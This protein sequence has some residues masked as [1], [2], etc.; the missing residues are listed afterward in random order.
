MCTEHPQPSGMTRRRLLQGAVAGL[1]AYLLAPTIRPGAARAALPDDGGVWLAG[2]LHC[3]TVL[4]HDVWGGPTDDNTGLEES[5]TLG[6]TAGEQITI[7][8]TRGLDFLAITDHNRVDTLRLPEY[9]SDRLT[10][11]PGY[12]HSLPGGHAGVFVPTV[13]V[14]DAPLDGDFADAAG[15]ARFAGAVHERGGLT[16]LNHPFDGNAS[17]GDAIAWGYDADASTVMDAVEVW[18]IAWQARHDTL[19]IADSDNH[20]SLAWWEQE[21]LP[22]RRMPMVGGSDNHYRATTAIQGVGQP[23][24]WVLAADRSTAALLDGIRAGRTT[25]SSQPPAHG[26]AQLTMAATHASGG[27]AVVGGEVRPGRS[28]VVV[29]VANGTGST[30]RVVVNGA[31]VHEVP[32]VAPSERHEVAVTL[33]SGAWVR[34]EL[35][36][37]RGYAMTALTSPIY[38]AP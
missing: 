12:E 23:T 30:L 9:R 4:S 37:D 5:W 24:T 26:G 14:L 33:P 35:Y 32:V 27:G 6:W 36:V 22:R 2:D 8:E 21:L 18:N 15:L 11:L 28:N 13:D 19:P 3:H 25:V 29:Q 38:A 31:A 17:E 7:A 16:V 20:L 10:L 34:A 1:G